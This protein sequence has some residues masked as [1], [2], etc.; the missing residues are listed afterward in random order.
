VNSVEGSAWH[1][2]SGAKGVGPKTLWRIADYLAGRKKT[3]AWLLKNFAE[4]EVAMSLSEAGIMIP[5]FGERD[6]AE[7]A[8]DAGRQ[9]TVLHPLHVDF[10]PRLK[11]LKDAVPLPALLY[12]RGNIALLNRPGVA[13]VGQRRAGEAELAA[14]DALAGELAG[15]GINVVSGYATGIDSAAHLGSLRAGGT[16]TMVLAEGIH[17]FHSRPEFL[18][19]LTVDNVLVVSQFPPDAKWTGYMAMARNKLVGALS[20][21][22]VV[23]ASGPERAVNGRRSGTFD[24]GMA[25]LKMGIPA[26]VVT[27]S[28]FADPP[29]GNRQLI[30]RGCRS[31][32]PAAGAAPILEALRSYREQKAPRQL[33]LFA[34][35]KS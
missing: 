1:V 27:P 2:L 19:H 7:L 12:V 18:D 8:A 4:K 11:T 5:G 6:Y 35:K 10:P 13:I 23:V 28:F 17:H 34:E 15:Q 3:A 21:A 9:A 33:N 16:T 26:F 32:D 22:V 31:W 14:A 30:A 20:G 25:A 24:A 29:V